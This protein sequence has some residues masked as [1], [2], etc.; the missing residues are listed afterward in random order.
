MCHITGTGTKAQF[1]GIDFIHVYSVEPSSLK[2]ICIHF[3]LGVA[4]ILIWAVQDL[5][6]LSDGDREISDKYANEDPLI[7]GKTYGI[8]QNGSVKVSLACHSYS[9]LITSGMQR[10]TGL[11]PTLPTKS[12]VATHKVISKAVDKIQSAKLQTKDQDPEAGVS[13][14]INS[15][16]DADGRK[17]AEVPLGKSQKRDRILNGRNPILQRNQS[18]IFK[19]FSKSKTALKKED[20]DSSIAASPETPAVDSVRLTCGNVAENLLMA[21]QPSLSTHE[22]RAFLTFNIVLLH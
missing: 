16:E 18:D 5:Q 1:E 8:I 22:D 11:R 21:R 14:S 19:S 13:S 17:A 10:R 15:S 6:F 4:P 3:A 9:G 2:V 7:F 12:A 20:T